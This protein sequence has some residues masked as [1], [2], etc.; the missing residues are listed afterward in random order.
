MVLNRA[1]I[2]KELEPGLNGIFGDVY[3]SYDNEHEY[4]FTQ[5]KSNR[6]FEEEV[7]FSGFGQAP[8][9]SEGGAVT[10]DDAQEGGVARYNHE[11]IA[12]AFAIT[13]EA[14]E[15]NL[16]APLAKRLTRAL[17]HS[18]AYTKQV[19]AANIFNNGFDNTYTFFDGKEFFATDHP[20]VGGGTF[21]NEPTT[22]V[23][24]SEDALENAVID[25]SQWVDE[26]SLK[27][28]VKPV[29]LHVPP[30]LQFVACRL[31]DSPGRPET[32]DNDLNAVRA[33]GVFPGGYF[34]QN[35][36]S[37]TDAWFVK[38]SENARG[39]GAK[40]FVRVPVQK[41]MEGD[42]ETGNM[43]YKA[44]ERYSFGVSNPRAYYASPGA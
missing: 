28:A 8:T 38:T 6:A 12:L 7:V 18:M 35:H 23:D 19:K 2:V 3:D 30:Q 40:Y 36:F 26:R 15:D 43:R 33:K 17:A 10:Y 20:L 41:K 13:E 37:D 44:R 22:A 25:I 5:D 31:L 27:I 39:F 34:V 32:A 16:Y 4:L 21:A 1:K 11:T 29:S 24:L 9:K 14:M 42:F